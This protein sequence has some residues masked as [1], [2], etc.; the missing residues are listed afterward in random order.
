MCV[1]DESEGR[2]KTNHNFVCCQISWEKIHW[3][4]YV[5]CEQFHLLK[6]Q[7]IPERFR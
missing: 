1:K 5:C 3:K 2:K 7:Q 4:I 6:Q